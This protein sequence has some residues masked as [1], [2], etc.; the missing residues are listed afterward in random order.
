MNRKGTGIEMQEIV[1]KAIIGLSA[2]ALIIAV[3]Y[4]AH[5]FFS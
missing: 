4:L 3:S 1:E 5:R 2:I